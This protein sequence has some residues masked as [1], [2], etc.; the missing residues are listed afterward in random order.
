[1]VFKELR[2]VFIDDNFTVLRVIKMIFNKAILTN[3]TLVLPSEFL[4][5]LMRVRVTIDQ[6]YWETFFNLFSHMLVST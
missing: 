2:Y 1:M 5:K 3:E 6:R 4:S